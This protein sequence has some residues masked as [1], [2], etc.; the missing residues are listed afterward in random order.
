MCVDVLM[1]VCSICSGE[2]NMWRGFG[3]TYKVCNVVMRVCNVV[4]KVCRCVN[5][6]V[7]C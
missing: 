3:E 4:M 2:E 1:R 7:L 6:T 5:E